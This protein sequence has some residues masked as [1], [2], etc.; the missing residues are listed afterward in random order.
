MKKIITQLLVITSL[1]FT[2]NLMAQTNNYT[3]EWKK[4]D[5]LLQSRL[6]KSA[7]EEINKIMKLAIA[8]KNLPQ[9][10]K[11]A[12]YQLYFRNLVE[13]NSA[14]KSIYALDSLIGKTAAPAK[15]ILQSIQAEVYIL[16]K[17]ANRY[18]LYNRTALQNEDSKDIS[19]WSLQRLNQQVNKL[20][21]ASLQNE[22]LLKNT[23][24]KSY[25]AIL[26][27]GK[28]TRQLRPTLYDLLAHR[29]LDYFMDTENDV[30]EPAFK[31]IIRDEKAFAPV[32][33]F[34]H[35]SFNSKDSASLHLHA[36]QIFQNLLT[37]HIADKNTDALL[38]A[39]LLR[40]N[41]V[42]Q[43]AVISNKAEW[44][45][46]ALKAFEKKYSGNPFV[47]Q[48]MYLRANIYLLNGRK[49]QPFSDTANQFEIKKAKELCEAA[50][51][52]YPNSEGAINCSNL[53]T[54]IKTPSLNLTTE[55]VNVPQ[56]PFRVLVQYKNIETLYFRA[57]K[58]NREE[59][60]KISANNEYNKQW[61]EFAG[62][63]AEKEWTVNLPQT[64]DYQNHSVE[65]KAD[66]LSEGIYIILASIYPN[67]STGNN[68]MAKQIV[69][70]SN[71]SYITNNKSQLYVLNRNTGLPIAN[72]TVQ[73]WEQTYNYNSRRYD[74]IKKGK[75][76]SDKNGFV[77]LQKVAQDY[78]AEWFQITHENDELFTDDY[79]YTNFKNEY[80]EAQVSKTFF[81]TDRSIYRPG[82]TVFFKGIV[83]NTN[84]KTEKSVIVPGHKSTILLFDANFQKIATLELT[85]N[86]YGSFNGSF[87]LPEGILNGAFHLTDSA[88][89]AQ[90]F[91]KVEEYKRPKF[92][93]EIKKPAGVYRVNDSISVTGNAKAYAGYN[94]D[95]AAVK[96]R[97]V[98][99]VQYPFWWGYRKGIW[100]P[101]NNNQLEITNGTTVTDADGNFKINF[102]AIPDEI[103]DKKFQPVFE[104]QVIADVTDLNG[105][106]RNGE[107]F[108]SVSY[109]SILLNIQTDEKLPA[110]SIHHILISTKN[111][112]DIFE[113]T[114]VKVT[115]QKLTEAGKIFRNRYW[116][117]PD[118]FVMSKDESYKT[119][120]F[121]VY[122]DEDQVNTWP[123][124]STIS[125]IT[126]STKENG[127]FNFGNKILTAGWYKITASA[128][129]KYG[130]T[131]A[132]ERFIYLSTKN[133]RVT[134]PVF[135]E[136]SKMALPGEKANYSLQTGFDKIWAIVSIS[137]NENSTTNQYSIVTG[138]QPLTTDFQITENERGG[139]S[140]AYAFV[141][142]NRFYSG[143]NGI[144]IPWNN[145]KLN[146]SYE[147]FREKLLPGS[148]EKWKIKI[149]GENTDKVAAEALISMYDA[150]LDQFA[151]HSWSSL[152]GLWPTLKNY[153]SFSTRNFTSI[154]SD[155]VN[156][157][158]VKYLQQK[159]KIY[160]ALI[161]LGWD[162]RFFT[163]RQKAL[164][165]DV[166][167]GLTGKVSGAYII[168]EPTEENGILVNEFSKAKKRGIKSITPNTNLDESADDGDVSVADTSVN[169]VNSNA[170]NNDFAF[171]KNFNETAFFFPDLRT[172]ANGN[173][174]F[175]FT[176]PEA[177]TSWKMMTLA[178]DKELASVYDEKTV[179]TQKPLMVQPFAPRFLR[180]GDQMEFS[181]KIVNLSDKEITGTSQ[182]Q[183][184]DA[185]T[186]TAIDG[187]F[188]N[189]FPTQ[190]FTVEAGKS[191]LV[192]F[193]IEIPFQFN[194]AMLY[195]IKAVAADNS[196]SDGEEMALPVLTNRTLVTESLP[197]NIRNSGSKSFT[198]SKL[199]NANSSGTLQHQSLTVEFTS[200]PA[201]YAIQ[202]LPYLME[203]PYECA[204]QTF[205]RFYANTL[206][207]YIA[208][209]NP[210][211]KALFEKWQTMDTAALLSN[212]Q[213]NE[214]LKSVLLQETPWVLEAKNENEQKKN[215]AL[216]FDM[217]RLANEKNK[218]LG[219]F[220]EAQT[221]NGGFSWFK[222]GPDDRY[223]TQYIIAGI[224]H[225]QK[226]NA[227][228]AEDN[229]NL[230]PLVDKALK[231]LDA[232]MKEDY[233][234]L[235]KHKLKLSQNNLSG[236]AIQYLYMRSFFNNKPVASASQKA[237]SYYRSQ[238]IK[239]WTV[240][241]KYYQAMIA[242]SL[243][244]TGNETTPKKIIQS[245]KENAINHEEMGMYWKEFTIRGYYWYQSPIESQALII[246]AFTN[247]DK[248]NNTIDD[249]KTWL[250]KN[251]QTNNWEST[252][253]TAE[254]CYAL[255]L[256]GSNWLNEDKN[257]T[258]QLG[259]LT[260]NSATEKTEAG[261]GYFK[262]TIDG[263]KVQQ[264]MGNIQ[265]S[266]QPQTN[267][268]SWGAV[269]WQYFEDLDKITPSQ[270][271]LKLVKKLFV[272]KN[273]D[274]GP[275][276]QAIT[277][278][279][280]LHKGDKVVVRIELYVDR[281]MEYVH[282]KDMRASCM[283][284]VN[285][286]SSYKWQGGL[287][288]YESTKDASTNFLFSHLPKG[289]YIFE[290]P[291]QV[292]HS[293][294]FSNGI[295]SIQC[296]YAPEFT[297]HSEGV[298]VN[299]EN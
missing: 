115:L 62:K 120:P 154:H 279:D 216:L 151:P 182:L 55:K 127:K 290:Y 108:V 237:Y 204:E 45:E 202:S 53:V 256:N 227:L 250:L 140:I 295:T 29:A 3:A 70:I 75:Y 254:A 267:S 33:E 223:I 193:P 217:V 276:L 287:G 98:R 205:N 189:V 38:D 116:P 110:D 194:S 88:N 100:P 130:E 51:T 206:A 111:S 179:I 35:T 155:E 136:A 174:E 272:E 1:L 131:V 74:E 137:K 80:P 102:L 23:S 185:A 95:G 255:L 2:T 168:N 78:K 63:K 40:L 128:K 109:Q 101:N 107:T 42:N 184:F 30:I 198:F 18:K 226:L 59:L 17:I 294:N 293:G 157:I 224:G 94:I 47:A 230:K 50:I 286:L 222:D 265:V 173:I 199:L 72:A 103:A 27:E 93:V 56:M 231:Y 31:F 87:K 212:L 144:Q 169:S 200:N 34:V 229:N 61:A 270:T 243:Y 195:R 73:V 241:N 285:V 139:I 225:L 275:V 162:N 28:N 121:D 165:S 97:V 292:T 10:V 283:E 299:V 46:N 298:R 21:K 176:M 203:Y 177:L 218:T 239:Y 4:I 181:A 36:L 105:E 251:K 32:E 207:A 289:N 123:V 296:M 180:E 57:I 281:E 68:Y 19:T 85:S 264:G 187:W 247:I 126:D 282:M 24:L 79:I 52:Q 253:A 113:K 188:K 192:N 43:H 143:N 13:E 160:D 11:A 14:E 41:F 263:K 106:T 133:S 234:Y 211:I 178:Y 186:N 240:M 238:A 170:P 15:N 146:I 164:N 132:T 197:L 26:Q 117:R 210:K 135:V 112:N 44:Y 77:Q 175:A 252:K 235:V 259:N 183:L 16:Y 158:P 274:R 167:Q 233:D 6:P 90:L 278:S 122:A 163:P 288:Y 119:F 159:E 191:V 284:P 5:K 12:M 58:T 65:I 215:I 91:F 76:I 141:K 219:K 22:E 244:R 246:E 124:Q 171:R 89:N 9:Q 208:G 273:S 258:I 220:A 125:E 172:D 249:L 60:K 277:E 148:E 236:Y 232:R 71:I 260:L 84:T 190:Y 221:S 147:T 134:D 7:L 242:L 156:T 150:S 280:V 129:D 161:N 86:D 67:F 196:F 138:K 261:T 228:S 257:V 248:N 153:T 66:A 54:Q 96:Y 82:Q 201:W 291:L 25:E 99:N 297:S 271:P 64:H 114:S 266:L 152:I 69:Y 8:Q 92:S 37:F 142:N 49:Y 209:S 48:A 39:D 145:K 245:L 269:Y 149:S 262:Q 166:A 104:Y 214:E 118:L 83:L 268:T 81:F 20:Y 213:K